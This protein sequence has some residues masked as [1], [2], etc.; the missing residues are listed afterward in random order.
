[1]HTFAQTVVQR[2]EQ[3]KIRRREKLL[4]QEKYESALRVEWKY[5][6]WM[7][8]VQGVDMSFAPNIYTQR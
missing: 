1:M 8:F 3:T 6:T 2:L 5:Q 7:Q 4:M